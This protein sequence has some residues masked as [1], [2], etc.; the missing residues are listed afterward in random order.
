MANP[1]S[2]EG[3]TILVT[4]ASSGIGQASCV[5][6]ARM[7]GTVIGSGRDRDRLAATLALLDSSGHQ[8]V[9]ADLTQP[10]D[11]AALVKSLPRLDGVLHS[12]GITMHIPFP[13][14]SAANL[15]EVYS[16]NYEA[17]MLVTQLLLKSRL[18]ADGGSII[19]IAST[20]GLFGWKALGSYAGT[21]G[22]LMASARVL[23]LE[24]APR[25]IRANCIAPAMVETPM[26]TQTED[27]VSAESMTEHRKLYPLGFGRPDDVANAVVYLLSDASRWVTG[28]TLV[29][30]GGYTCQ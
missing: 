19:F 29:L 26:A 4:G 28:T 16:I 25:R 3:K 30:D 20:A 17:P 11:R 22:A 2:L 13:F 10:A 9:V 6:I 1:F 14:I 15:K 5:A 21:K 23:A 24:I 7:G 8:T 18:M 12:A 27:L